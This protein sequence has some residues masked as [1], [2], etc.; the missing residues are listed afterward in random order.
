MDIKSHVIERSF[1]IELFV[2]ARFSMDVESVQHYVVLYRRR[3]DE[4]S[5]LTCK[6][7][8]TSKTRMVQLPATAAIE[9]V[10]AYCITRT[11]TITKIV[12]GCLCPFPPSSMLIRTV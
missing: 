6:G 7:T 8:I 2:I 5:S 9:Y 11:R 4:C 1:E 3:V 12:P 10:A